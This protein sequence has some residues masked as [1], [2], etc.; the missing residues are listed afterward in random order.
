MISTENTSYKY[1]DELL[2]GVRVNRVR[3]YEQKC[4]CL[5]CGKELRCLGIT[6]KNNMMTGMYKCTD[7]KC[8]EY[9][10]TKDNLS[11]KWD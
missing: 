1:P 7:S 4:Y 6:R 9:G 8:P 11:V 3:Q 2:N 10:I 5:D